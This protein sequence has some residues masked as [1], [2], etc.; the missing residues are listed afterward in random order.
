[1]ELQ[2]II[3]NNP[4]E[5]VGILKKAMGPAKYKKLM[6]DEDKHQVFWLGVI[7]SLGD[8]DWN[9]DPLQYLILSGFNEIRNYNKEIWSRENMRYCSNCNR[10]HGYR[11]KICPRCGQEMG[12][13]K[14]FNIL[15][16]IHKH[17]DDFNFSIDLERFVDTLSGKQRYIA[18]RWLLDRV[19][20]MF[21]NHSKQ[22][23]Q[24]LGCSA[25]MIS[26]YKKQIRNRFKEWYNG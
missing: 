2:T 21:D 23:A 19:D 1:M 15:S 26:K 12:T 22:L 5:I 13:I 16:D 8:V 4:N 20:L 24:E 18:K 7:K 3:E 25:P 11:T 17:Y 10:I 9:R 14:R 6:S